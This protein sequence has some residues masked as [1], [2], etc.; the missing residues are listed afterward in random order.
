MWKCPPRNGQRAP[1]C[2]YSFSTWSWLFGFHCTDTHTQN[3]HTLTNTRT[4]TTTEQNNCRI[5]RQTTCCLVGVDLPKIGPKT[6]SRG[7]VSCFCASKP[8]TN[9]TFSH[10]HKNICNCSQLSESS[11]TQSIMKETFQTSRI[12]MVKWNTRFCTILK[13]KTTQNC[14]T[15][16]FYTVLWIFT[17][18][19]RGPR[20]STKSLIIIDKRDRQVVPRFRQPSL[21]GRR[22]VLT[23]LSKSP[24]VFGVPNVQLLTHNQIGPKKS[25]LFRKRSSCFYSSY[26]KLHSS[27][28]LLLPARRYFNPFQSVTFYALSLKHTNFRQKKSLTFAKRSKN[29]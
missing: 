29:Q 11:E 20:E 25:P 3:S 19:Q 4:R 17:R 18:E 8:E 21:L 1:S 27:S 12:A 7:H 15:P 22:E 6:N 16:F 2:G 13:R 14:K 28:C 5:V 10:T 9:E 24:N 23:T 26:R